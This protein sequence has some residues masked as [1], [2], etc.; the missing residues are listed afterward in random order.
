MQPLTYKSLEAGGVS[1]A[2]TDGAGYVVDGNVPGRLIL[3]AETGK[4]IGTEVHR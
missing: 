2:Q 3:D 4:M 1:H